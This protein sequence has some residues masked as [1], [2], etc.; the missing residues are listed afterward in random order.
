M[1]VLIILNNSQ[2]C[3]YLKIFLQKIQNNRRIK[4]KKKSFR[5]ICQIIIITNWIYSQNCYTFHSRRMFDHVWTFLQ[6]IIADN[7]DI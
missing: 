7:F 2:N 3:T 4:L 6:V 5:V 1:I